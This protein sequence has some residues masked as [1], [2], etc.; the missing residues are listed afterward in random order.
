MGKKEEFEKK[1]PL[2]IQFNLL[3]NK[4]KEKKEPINKIVYEIMF[5]ANNFLKKY[6]KKEQ[7]EEII[8]AFENIIN[9]L[10]YYYGDDAKALYEN[11]KEGEILSSFDSLI[12]DYDYKTE[13]NKLKENI[14]EY[15][16]SYNKNDIS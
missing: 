1:D 15:I 13:I 10:V 8:I 11:D 9:T 5:L 14:N 12:F 16:E 6:S 4:L 7:L 3:D 2:W